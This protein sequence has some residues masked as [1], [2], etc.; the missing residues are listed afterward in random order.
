MKKIVRF[1]IKAIT[2]AWLGASLPAM[3]YVACLIN[4]GSITR[5][6]ALGMGAG[7]IAVLVLLGI[8]VDRGERK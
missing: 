7:Y 1:I 6:Y 4:A 8:L 2:C 5:A 3:L